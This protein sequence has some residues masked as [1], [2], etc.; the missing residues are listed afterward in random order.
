MYCNVYDPLLY[1]NGG[2]K[3]AHFF[4][5]KPLATKIEL[6]S[7]KERKKCQKSVFLNNEFF[8]QIRK[9]FNLE[10]NHSSFLKAPLNVT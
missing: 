8:L 9:T 3:L 4:L 6:D 10:V 1:R 5:E 2:T 7:Q